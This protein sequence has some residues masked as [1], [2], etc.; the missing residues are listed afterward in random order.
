VEETTTE[1]EEVVRVDTGGVWGVLGVVVVHTQTKGHWGSRGKNPGERR[2]HG[3]EK[4]V[5]ARKE[6]GGGKG[7]R[8]GD[9]VI[10]WRVWFLWGSELKGQKPK[11]NHNKQRGGGV[12]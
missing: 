6:G 11:K 3:C 7:G 1:G 2:E 9:L 4:Q 10:Q 8:G 5:L 12:P